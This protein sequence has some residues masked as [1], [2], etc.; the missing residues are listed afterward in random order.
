MPTCHCCAADKQFD[1][2]TARSDLKRYRRRGPERSTRHLLAAIDSVALPRPS[3]LLDIGGGIG[4]IQHHLLSHGFDRATHV[5][6]SAA[7]IEAS[8]HEAE[9]LGHGDRVSYRHAD[10][11][12]VADEIPSADVVTL[13]RVVCCDPDFTT[14]LGAAAQHARR[15]LA[16]VYP[17]D[18][19]YTRTFV[20]MANWWRRLFG[21]SFTAYVHPPAAMAA[22][23]EEGGL[24]RR[25]AGGTLVWV[26]EVYE[27]AEP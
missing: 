10:F 1:P 23:I 22:I 9:Q 7:Y 26:V 27:R 16:L 14:L 17:R 25:W 6:A 8:H 3:T 4:A 2:G 24:R 13:D 15:L 20:C 11:R 12:S 21:D 19:W 18:R 5:D